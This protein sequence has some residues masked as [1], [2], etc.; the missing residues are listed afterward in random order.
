[1]L[2]CGSLSFL[3]DPIL[4]RFGLTI[5][6]RYQDLVALAILALTYAWLAG[7]RRS[8]LPDETARFLVAA[9]ALVNLVF[10]AVSKK[11]FTGYLIFAMYPAEFII[12]QRT[13]A[14]RVWSL[15]TLALATAFNLLLSVEPT[16]WFRL[17][18][19]GMSLE[20]WI[21]RGPRYAVM[22]FGL[23][24]VLLLNCYVLL[25]WGSVRLLRPHAA[26]M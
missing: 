4:T 6:V 7:Q 22:S 10:L 17:G 8:Q 20:E 16:L 19:N 15:W 5:I 21:A 23:V 3:L 14:S 24:D 13:L 9:L 26:S 2:S 12:V 18:G 1:L 25:A 11:S